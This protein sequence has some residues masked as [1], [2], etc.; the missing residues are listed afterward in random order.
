[1]W[2]GGRNGDVGRWHDGQF[3]WLGK[4]RWESVRAIHETADGMWIGTGHG[5]FRM[6]GDRL[7]LLRHLFGLEIRIPF[8]R[9]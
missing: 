2:F 3:T 4:A 8:D 5:L 6:H 9:L 7:T 1:V